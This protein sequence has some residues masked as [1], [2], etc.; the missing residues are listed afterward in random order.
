[1]DLRE[2]GRRGWGRG[3][4][5]IETDHGGTWDWGQKDKTNIFTSPH[6]RWLWAIRISEPTAAKCPSSKES[7]FRVHR[8]RK[9]YFDGPSQKVT[10]AELLWRAQPGGVLS[11]SCRGVV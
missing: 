8:T 6:S 1:M 11:P 4:R 10:Q 7:V 3:Q 2:E 9:Q 5:D